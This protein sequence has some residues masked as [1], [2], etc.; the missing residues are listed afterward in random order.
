M[1]RS[2]YYVVTVPGRGREHPGNIG[3]GLWWQHRSLRRI[4]CLGEE[5]LELGRRRYLKDAGIVNA[6]D[7]K[8]VGHTARKEDEPSRLNLPVVISARN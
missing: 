1:C 2:T 8:G 7:R 6:R 5:A 3:L 4:A